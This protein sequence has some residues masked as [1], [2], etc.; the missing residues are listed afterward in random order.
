MHNILHNRNWKRKIYIYENNRNNSVNSAYAGIRNLCMKIVE[1][2]SEVL[3]KE[4]IGDRITCYRNFIVCTLF[5]LYLQFV[6]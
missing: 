2:K 5:Q 4:N 6:F 3:D 1:R